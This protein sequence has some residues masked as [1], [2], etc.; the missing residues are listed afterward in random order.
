MNEKR[1][2]RVVE[3]AELLD[4]FHDDLYALAYEEDEARGRMPSVFCES[5]RYVLSADASVYLCRAADLINEALEVLSLIETPKA[6]SIC[7]S[8]TV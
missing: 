8:E 2:A 1:Y 6:V 3:L 4:G 7:V 5:E